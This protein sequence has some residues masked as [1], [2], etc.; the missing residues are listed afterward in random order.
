MKRATPQ[1]SLNL[2]RVG[3]TVF[4]PGS[5]PGLLE[6]FPLFYS[7]EN[8]KNIYYIEDD[9]G[10]PISSAGIYPSICSLNGLRIHVASLGNVWTLPEHRGKKLASRIIGEIVRDLEREEESLLLVS[11]EES[12]YTRIGCAP[13]GKMIIA[14]FER[15]TVRD[16][17]SYEFQTIHV[18]PEDRGFHAKELL[19]IYE[20][21]P[22]RYLRNVSQM[23][24]FLRTLGYLHRYSDRQ[25]FEIKHVGKTVAYAVAGVDSLMSE[26]RFA[27]IIEWAGSRRAVVFSL[28]RISEYYGAEF[29]ELHALPSDVEMMNYINDFKM[30]FREETL[31]GTVRPLNIEY[32]FTELQPWFQ[33]TLGGKVRISR[34]IDSWLAEGPFGKRNIDSYEAMSRWLF[35][36]SKDSLGIPLM[37]TDNLNYI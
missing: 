14:I 7:P 37:M 19:E 24:A 35:D 2:A 29:V 10:N 1:I 27:R 17:S 36:S 3:N 34:G 8:S 23:E 16:S 13:V 6:D 28:R 25:L 11:G 26:T 22:F 5:E 31:Q 18:K 33:K 12:I 30:N 4:R 20:N 21:E 9:S 15:S 32:L